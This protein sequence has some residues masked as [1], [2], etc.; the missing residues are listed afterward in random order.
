MQISERLKKIALMVSA[1][2]R[3]ADVGT[4]H[5]YVP[6]YLYEKKVISSAIAMDV[7]E[8]PLKRA[9]QHIREAGL[10]KVIETRLSDGLEKLYPGEAETILIAGM[11]GPLMIRILSAKPDV[12]A[13]VK[14]LVLQPQSEIADVREWLYQHGYEIVKEHI[15][16]EEGKYYPMFRAV[17]KTGAEEPEKWVYRFGNPDIQEDLEILK[18][19]LERELSKYE[20][21]MGK[22]LEENTKKAE[23]RI[24]ELK[25]ERSEIENMLFRISKE[26]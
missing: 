10:E 12:T 15:V 4:D 5:G 25:V 14:E 1:G 9:K 2:N 18:D 8:G 16:L 17:P 7:N 13:S 19:Y 6:I 20:T 11:G 3:L 24:E 26:I 23:Y 22:L 21:I